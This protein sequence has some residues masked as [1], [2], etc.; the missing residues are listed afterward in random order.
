MVKC[1]KTVKSSK[2]AGK[3][4][5]KPSRSPSKK[6]IKKLIRKIKSNPKKTLRLTPKGKSTQKK[7]PVRLARPVM[8]SVPKIDK[9]KKLGTFIYVGY[10]GRGEAVRMLLYHAKII[11]DMVVVTRE[12]I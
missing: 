4:K 1:V 9:T 6:A 8:K 3:K 10:Y 2:I 11:Y 7:K 12:Q 5:V